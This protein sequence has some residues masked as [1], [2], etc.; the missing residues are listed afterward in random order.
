MPHLPGANEFKASIQ[1]FHPENI[2]HVFTFIPLSDPDDPEYIRQMRRPAE[3]KE[4]V[5]QMEHRQRVSLILNSAAF[6]E[7]LEQIITD[8]ENEHPHPTS[9]EAIR[10]I[11]ELILPAGRFEQK[12]GI[13][14]GQWYTRDRVGRK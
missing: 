14:R 11:K 10:Q 12:N 6:R 5:K 9:M 8:Y 4:D 1:K 13:T 7:E 2:L 3:V